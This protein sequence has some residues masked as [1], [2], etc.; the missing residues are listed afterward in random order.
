MLSSQVFKA[1]LLE[2]L[3]ASLLQG[4]EDLSGRLVGGGSGKP[5]PHGGGGGG[6]H[7][8]QLQVSTVQKQSAVHHLQFQFT[9]EDRCDTLPTRPPAK[10]LS[11]ISC[12]IAHPILR[13]ACRKAY[14]R[15]DEKVVL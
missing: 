3:R 2:E 12:S 13:N 15:L 11:A 14:V 5:A 7:Y 9:P 1:L 8:V 10:Q 6:V 4:H